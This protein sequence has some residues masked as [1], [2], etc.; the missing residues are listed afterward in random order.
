VVL[1]TWREREAIERTIPALLEQL[2][3]GDELVVSDNDSRDGSLDAVARLAPDAKVVRN[4]DNLGFTGGCNAGAAAASGDLLLFLNPD[5]VPQP[6]FVRAIKAPMRS[7]GGDGEGDG[8]RWDA[9]MGLVTSEDGRILNTDGNEIHFTGICWAGGDGR[10]ASQA[11]H[12]AREVPYLSGACLAVPMD[13]WRRYGGFPP[14]FFIYHEDVDIS[15]HVRLQGGHVG[16]EP[17]AVV[18]HDYEFTKGAAKW[19]R[20]ERNRWAVILRNYPTALLLAVLPALLATELALLA[21]AVVN[22]WGRQKLYAI[23]D[24]IRALPRL[25]R[26]RREI[27]AERRIS[28]AE[29]A[30]WLTPDLDSRYLGRASRSR[31]L[32]LGLRAYWA[33]VRALLRVPSPERAPARGG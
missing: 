25:L 10:P 21:V 31:A 22:G 18:D 19:R 14:P 29:F 9:W 6:G 28:A 7:S 5:A 15:L 32:R 30:A 27:Q 17:D 23:A 4:G 1:I 16:I 13:V 20:L 2:E 26:E 33:L 3:P 12:T 24:T 8:R 11:A